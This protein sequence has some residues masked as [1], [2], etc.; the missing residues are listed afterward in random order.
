M[1]HDGCRLLQQIDHDMEEGGIVPVHALTQEMLERREAESK[2][3][4]RL[5]ERICRADE[6]ALASLFDR[7]ADR[8]FSLAVGIVKNADDAEE[9]VAE[10]FNRIWLRSETYDPAR[11]NVVAWMSVM[12]RSI[13]LDL[14]RRES[15]HGKRQVYPDN[16]RP[17]CPL[18]ATIEPESR[19]DRALFRAEAMRAMDEMSTGQQRVLG[20]AYFQDLSHQEIARR[21]KM[22][23]GTVKSHCR[24]GLAH[25]KHL[26]EDFNPAGSI[27]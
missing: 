20:L 8:M 22:P 18:N 24:R 23:L 7:M 15:R 5:V 2:Q 3:L 14:L 26:L 19:A 1:L 27:R 11:G 12:C 16:L 21:L 10:L 13:S 25:L 6:S 17:A 4:A 9:V